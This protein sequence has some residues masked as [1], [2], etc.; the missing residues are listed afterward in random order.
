[1]PDLIIRLKLR[2][3]FSSQSKPEAVEE[4][5]EICVPL[6]VQVKPLA[7]GQLAFHIERFA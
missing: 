4:A 3:L 2:R 5:G 7:L 6:E 1:M